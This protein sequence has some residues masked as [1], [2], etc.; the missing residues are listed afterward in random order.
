METTLDPN[1]VDA[2]VGK[3]LGDGSGA[4][5]ML[6]AAIGDRLGLFK[7][8]DRNGPATSSDLAARTGIQERYAREWLGGMAAAGYVEY[9]PASRR[10]TLPSE[11]AP[12]LAHE[13]GP[14]FF[15]AVF[16]FFP[17]WFALLDRMVDVF[18]IGGGIPQTDYDPRLWDALERFTAGWFDNFLCQEWIPAMPDVQAKLERGVDLSDVGCGRGR[19]LIKLAQVFP[20]SRYVGYDNHAPSINLA[21]E[22]A[23]AAGVADRV[24]FTVLDVSKGIPSKHDLITT[25]DVVHDAVDPKGLL[26]AIRDA[27]SDDGIYVCLDVNASHRVED[28]MGPLATFFY[29]ASVSYCMTSSLAHGGAGLGTLGFNEKTAREMCQ[30]VGFSAVRRIPLENPFNILYEIRS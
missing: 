27:L 14:L 24:T 25:F 23:K 20:R 30:E 26:R 7:D 19:A 21:T 29:G 15:G 9:D 1:R 13:S 17:V 28:N 3:V 18:R 8:L 11:H 16:Q 22:R 5:A 2:F 4:S 12:A 6:L 10:F